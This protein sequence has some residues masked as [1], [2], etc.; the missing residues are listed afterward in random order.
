MLLLLCLSFRRSC[1]ASHW[2]AE[3]YCHRAECA[4]L[5]EQQQA[6]WLPVESAE[7]ETPLRPSEWP[8]D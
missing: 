7:E 6:E 3:G 4:D 1:Q 2:K 5:Q 8:S